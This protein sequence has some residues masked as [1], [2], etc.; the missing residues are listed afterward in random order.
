[1]TIP[2]RVNS[3]DEEDFEYAGENYAFWLYVIGA[4]ACCI[5]FC[6]FIY[7]QVRVIQKVGKSDKIIPAML[8]ML[9]FSALSM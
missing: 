2:S 7:I 6:V 3:D 5:T 1:M 8:L 9:Q 4:I